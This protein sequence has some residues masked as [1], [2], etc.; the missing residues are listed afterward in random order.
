MHAFVKILV[1]HRERDTEGGNRR[2]GGRGRE[3]ERERGVRRGER[4]GVRER[5][6]GILLFYFF[7]DF[8]KFLAFLSTFSNAKTG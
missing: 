3:R 4:G 1:H 7:R 2:E 8:L 5:L 6:V